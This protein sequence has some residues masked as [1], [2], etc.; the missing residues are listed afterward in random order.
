MRYNTREERDWLKVEHYKIGYVAGVFD[1]FHI[2][3]LNLIRRAKEHCDYLIAGVLEDELV[4]RFKNKLPY[5]PF[6]ERIQIVEAIKYVDKAVRVDIT[7]IDKM[8]AWRAFQFDC[9]FSGDD[10]K[11]SPSWIQDQLNLR[12]VGSDLQYFSYTKSTNSTEIRK[13]IQKDIES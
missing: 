6:E 11:D 9:F 7:N 1:L 8:E 5:I 2:G 12:E 3:H 4:Q 10:W 13:L